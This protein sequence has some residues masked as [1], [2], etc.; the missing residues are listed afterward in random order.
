MTTLSV[1]ERIIQAI[2]ARVGASRGLESYDSRRLPVT[3]L[4][5]GEDQPGE[6]DY[7]VTNL[8]LP[9]TV[10]RAENPQGAKGDAWHTAANA[11]LAAL[12]TEI[13]AGG[14][15]I[16]GLGTRIDYTGGGIGEIADAASGYV[17]QASIGV[18]YHFVRGNPYSHDPYAVDDPEPEEE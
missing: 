17:V 13:Y 5:E 3:V 8:I 4:V 7:D 15:D 1:R 6:P 2:A 11:A 12:I 10:A 14:E 18:N 16:A 9:L